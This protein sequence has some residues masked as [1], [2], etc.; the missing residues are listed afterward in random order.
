[1]NHLGGGHDVLGGTE[2]DALDEHR[3]VERV[4]QFA[5]VQRISFGQRIPAIW[6]SGALLAERGGGSHLAAGHSVDAVVDEDD[7]DGFAAVGGVDDFG[8]P[9]GRQIAIALV[10]DD[11]AFRTAALDGGRHGGGAAV[12]RLD[13]ADIEIVVRE[14]RAADR[15]DQHGAVLHAQVFER[16]RQQFVRD[17]VAA[18]GTVV[19]LVLQLV[20]AVEAA[21]KNR[22]LSWVTVRLAMDEYL[23]KSELVFHRLQHLFGS[24]H[25]AADAA[26]ELHRAAA[27][28]RQA[29]IV[30]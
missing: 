16:L 18:S 22:R 10:G 9:D 14:Y 28:Q 13:V 6:R 30:A 8:G 15:A 26:E 12:R 2:R 7:G 20:L 5:N 4:Q 11:N 17:A 27:L 25:H 23:R 29:N 3:R 1:V 21:V 24:R 19:R